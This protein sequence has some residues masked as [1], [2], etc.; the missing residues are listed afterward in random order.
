M[1]NTQI[2][3]LEAQT[4]LH[5]SKIEYLETKTSTIVEQG[6]IGIWNYEKWSNGKIELWGHHENTIDNNVTT[7]NLPFEM[8]NNVY[9]VFPSICRE[10]NIVEEFWLGTES[11]AN[12]KN[13]TS[14]K[15]FIKRNE[16]YKT[17]AVGIDF[18]V[19]GYYKK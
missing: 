7:V 8:A 16:D 4:T 12:D 19:K 6:Q 9:T 14:F 10:G 5:K 13:T 3:E 18:L 17:F 1:H 15:Y 11:G 2:E